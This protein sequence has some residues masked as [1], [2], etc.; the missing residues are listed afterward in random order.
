MPLLHLT[1]LLSFH[2]IDFLMT[3]Y[4]REHKLQKKKINWRRYEI[5]KNDG[6]SYSAKDG[7]VDDNIGIKK[8]T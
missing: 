2:S 5:T 8:V 3:S 1:K 6:S 4:W 7:N